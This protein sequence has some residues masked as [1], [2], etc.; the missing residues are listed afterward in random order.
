MSFIRNLRLSWKLAFAFGAVTLLCLLQGIAALCGFYR[1]DNLTADIVGHAVPSVQAIFDIRTQMLELRRWDLNG[2]LA[3]TDSALSRDWDQH[4]AI[5]ERYRADLAKYEPLISR[6]DERDL[7][8]GFSNSFSRY[9]T[10]SDEMWRLLHAG[11]REEAKAVGLDMELTV[12]V[13]GQASELAAK[14]LELNSSALAEDG[15]RI[16]NLDDYLKKMGW[17]LLVVVPMLAILFSRLLDRAITPAIREISAALAAVANKDLTITVK[18]MAQDEIGQLADDLNTSVGSMRGVLESIAQGTETL[19][20]ASSELSVRAAQSGGNAQTQAS[21]TNMIAAAAQEMTASISEISSNAAS[22]AQASQKSARDAAEGG[23]VMKETSATMER[24]SAAATQAADKMLSLATR[25]E[26]IGKVVNVIQEISEQTNL[27]ALNAAIEAARAGE[28]GR[29]FAVVA[30]EVRRLAERTN[31]ATEEIATTIRRMQ[32]ETTQTADVMKS[33]R[34]EVASGIEE[35][36]KAQHSLAEIIES[37]KGVDS[38]V[39][40]IAAAATEQTAASSEISESASHISQLST[41]NLQAAEETAE[42]C[43]NLSQLANELEGI[44]VQFTFSARGA[45]A[46]AGKKPVAKPASTFARRPATRLA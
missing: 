38:M 43:K 20:A 6:S 44:L 41:E 7:Y 22:A 2:M 8:Q 35:T 40:L 31:S 25:S 9:L 34:A 36:A 16:S 10:R 1:A 46:L 29:G 19:S 12:K 24:I 5:V 14:D 4:N 37:A 28:H 26:E 32:D 3:E 23:E 39:Q 21:K 15:T 13:V 42:A 17:T 18:A 33:S 11:K 45:E 30:G 27:L